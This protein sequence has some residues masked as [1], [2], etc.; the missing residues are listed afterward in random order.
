[1]TGPLSMP[2]GHAA[3]ERYLDLLFPEAPDDAWIVVSCRVP[4]A[5]FYSQWFLTGDRAA[6]ITYI[7]AQAE[8]SNVHVGLGLRQ[9]QCQ[10]QR[11]VRGTNEDVCGI[12]GLWV[13]CDHN[14]GRH[15]AKN[16]PSPD[17]LRV[18]LHTL[19]FPF[20]L[21]VDSG[22]GFHA[23]LLFKEL[24]LF[25][26]S[27]ERAAAALLLK[28]FQRTLQLMATAAGWKIDSTAD[29]ARMLRPAGTYNYKQD[30]PHAVTIW[31]EHDCRYNPS[32]LADAP[33]LVP[34]EDVYTPS[35]TQ[36]GPFADAEFSLIETQCAWMAHCRDDAIH[37][38]EPEWYAMLGIVGRCDH[39]EQLAHTLSEPYPTYLRAETTK[40]LAQALKTAGPRTCHAI[41]YDL[42][43][44]AYCQGCLFW[45]H[46]KSPI[47]LGMPQWDDLE[48]TPDPVT[49]TEHPPVGFAANGAT[50]GKRPAS[51][52]RPRKPNAHEHTQWFRDKVAHY[53]DKKD[54]I[55]AND[56]TICAFLRN[57]PHWEGQLWWDGMANRA[58]VG[59][60]ALTDDVLVRIGEYF[61][62]HHNLPI[63]TS[64]TKLAK[65]IAAVCKDFYRD[66]LQ[67]Y[68]LAL[69]GWDGIT[70][71]D[72]W[73]TDCAGVV[74]DP[75]HQFLSRTLIVS[76]IARAFEPGCIYRWVVVFQGDEEFRKST[77][78]DN[79][80][81]RA[82]WVKPITESFESKDMPALI[83][84]LWLA[85]LAELDSLS[86]T[87]ETR[88]KS[89]ITKRDDAYVPKW[90]LFRVSQ[91]RRTI[92]IGTTNKETWLKS[93]T[94]NTRW[95]PC[96]IRHEMDVDAFVAIREQLY[97]EAMAYYGDHAEDWWHMSPEVEAEAKRQREERREIS[98]YESDLPL[99]LEKTRFYDT[100]LR[101][102]GIVS[103]KEYVTWP[104]LA[105]GYLG[106]ENRERWKDLTMQKQ[107]AQSLHALGWYPTV[108][109]DADRRS[110]RMWK[111]KDVV[112]F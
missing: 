53:V 91:L 38:T 37:L 90:G 81:P 63:R 27:D 100:R 86:R 60:E 9:P 39:G 78:V 33:W 106:L 71:L 4:P 18:F 84:G 66:P 105:A 36:G 11:N 56:T 41:R 10:P 6:L 79:M 80:V 112:P 102:A 73:L 59:E 7:S 19:P 50:P 92:F 29:L 72:T 87:E 26:T 109:K 75:Y 76:M 32:E 20:S 23:Y 48:P 22:G 28:R 24:W 64:G 21:I 70:R 99:W 16:L 2:T 44:E 88:L 14:A 107:L 54:I 17:A 85:E 97:C 40:K 30:T 68:L 43:A 65:C 69:E 74:C 83:S 103:Q 31:E 61:G 58:M 94:G 93:T 57:H 8:T 82:E 77:F 108:G 89:F 13:E 5:Q 12:G 96:H 101:D 42:D 46:I 51:P 15:A 111:P 45:G 98:V 52:K 110:L 62:E 95:L 104:E 34:L 25:D 35:S 67:E 3:L 47:T 55:E 1:M 49:G